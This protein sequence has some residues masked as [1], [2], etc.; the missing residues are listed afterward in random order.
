MFWTIAFLTVHLQVVLSSTEST[1]IPESCPNSHVQEGHCYKEF[2]RFS[3]IK[4]D[5]TSYLHCCRLDRY[6]DCLV[7]ELPAPCHGGI[8]DIT[9]GDDQEL[10]ESCSGTSHRSIECSVAFNQNV[11]I[12]IFACLVFLSLIFS[13]VSFLKTI[14]NCCC[15]P[16][17]SPRINDSFKV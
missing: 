5:V 3:R 16:E 7:D 2:M 9:F 4:S 14:F 10:K 15:I 1:P 12:G 17:P 8:L 13:L 11:V 6:K